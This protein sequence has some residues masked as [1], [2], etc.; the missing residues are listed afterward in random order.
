VKGAQIALVVVCF[1][2][3]G[4][5]WYWLSGDADTEIPDTDEFATM[6][7]CDACG[8]L[9]SLTPRQYEDELGSSGGAPP[10]HCRKCAEQKAWLAVQ[11]IQCKGWFFAPGK[12]DARGVCP[13]CD[14]APK[15]GDTYYE[16]EPEPSRP[17]VDAV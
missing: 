8:E 17:A 3:A 10:L 2:A 9:F 1:A 4:L 15:P 11:C 12:P 6:W 13:V 5:L 7:K 14:P 16:P